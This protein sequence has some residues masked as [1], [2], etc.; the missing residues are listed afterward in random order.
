MLT[1]PGFWSN[2]LRF[3]VIYVLYSLWHLNSST[4]NNLFNYFQVNA[5][6]IYELTKSK[7]SYYIF[8]VCM[9]ILFFITYLQKTSPGFIPANKQVKQQ[10]NDNPY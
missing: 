5:T 7:L 6:Y 10:N 1:K 9:R 4:G 2:V 3:K 8:I